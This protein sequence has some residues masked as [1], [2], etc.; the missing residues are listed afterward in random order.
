MDKGSPNTMTDSNQF[1]VYGPTCLNTGQ[2]GTTKNNNFCRPPHL[3]MG[4][5][6]KI[7]VFQLSFNNL[8]LIKDEVTL[9][10]ADRRQFF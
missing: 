10:R 7:G 2:F 5:V 8:P 6:L 4:N 3:F 1:V 9:Y